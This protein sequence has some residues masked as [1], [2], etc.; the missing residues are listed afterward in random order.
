M[1]RPQKDT[2]IPSSSRLR[3]I[4]VCFRT[5][6]RAHSRFSKFLLTW[7]SLIHSHQLLLPSVHRAPLPTRSKPFTTHSL[8]R[9]SGKN[10]GRTEAVCVIL[11]AACRMHTESLFPSMCH[12]RT[13]FVMT[14]CD[15]VIWQF[16]RVS[17]CVNNRN[18]SAQPL[19]A[20]PSLTCEVRVSWRP[21]S[22]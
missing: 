21:Y 14:Q 15:G 3:C 9:N 17:L 2:E 10:S 8:A 20:M 11:S 19:L 16:R 7:R 5:L 12:F 4:N 1:L 22:R 6:F 13:A 18:A